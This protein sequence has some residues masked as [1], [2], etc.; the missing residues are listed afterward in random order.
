VINPRIKSAYIEIEASYSYSIGL[1]DA[2]YP[3]V[4][5]S[6]EAGW[7]EIASPSSRYKAVYDA[8]MEGI[9]LYYDVMRV[10]E[11]LKGS[12]GAQGRQKAFKKL[13]VDEILYKV[14]SCA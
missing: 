13:A 2:G 14:C 6:G 9:T 3:V 4:W 7:F 1:D 5:V 11:K 12:K 8:V 10:Y